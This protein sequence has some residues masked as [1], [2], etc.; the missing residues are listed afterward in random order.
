MINNPKQ[1]ESM[2]WK[3]GF[4]TFRNA[5]MNV[6]VNLIGVTQHYYFIYRVKFHFQ[7]CKE[8]ELLRKVR[9]CWTK[10]AAFLKSRGADDEQRRSSHVQSRL[11]C[12]NPLLMSQKAATSLRPR[13]LGH[14]LLTSTN[15]FQQAFMGNAPSESRGAYFGGAWFRGIYHLRKALLL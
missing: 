6:I 7:S 15:T 1:S 9:V 4:F 5:N 10:W 14:R 13:R 3:R 12:L 8:P 2:E 11:M